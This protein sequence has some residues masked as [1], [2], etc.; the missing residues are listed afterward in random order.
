MEKKKNEIRVIEKN[1]QHE[2]FSISMDMVIIKNG[3]K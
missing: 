2:Y 1:V 3:K